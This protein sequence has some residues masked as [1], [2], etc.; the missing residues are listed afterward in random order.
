MWVDTATQNT[1][2]VSMLN[3]EHSVKD[4]Y[5]PEFIYVVCYKLSDDSEFNFMAAFLNEDDAVEYSQRNV[6]SHLKMFVTKQPLYKN[7]IYSE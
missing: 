7:S 3:Q 2:N 5:M 4:V 6:W 1:K